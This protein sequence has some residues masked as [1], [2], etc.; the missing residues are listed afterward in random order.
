MVA[1][2]PS[3]APAAIPAAIPADAAIAIRIREILGA[4]GGYDDVTVQVAD[5]IV[6][7]RGT[8]TSIAEASDLNQLTGRVAGVV[9]G[10]GGLAGCASHG[11]RPSGASAASVE[12]Q[13][14]QPFGAALL[15]ALIALSLA[16]SLTTMFTSL[17]K[18]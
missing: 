2:P 11:T 7:L 10:L 14:L 1:P 6:T 12:G 17:S 8:T 18:A 13:R 16:W 9:A 4:L 3:W 5:G 15:F